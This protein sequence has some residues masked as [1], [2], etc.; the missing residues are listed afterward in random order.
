M[1]PS[2]SGAGVLASDG[3]AGMKRKA[4]VAGDTISDIYEQEMGGKHHRRESGGGGGG[5][6]RKGGKKKSR[7]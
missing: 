6:K 1:K 4:G 3:G 7:I 5:G 2:S